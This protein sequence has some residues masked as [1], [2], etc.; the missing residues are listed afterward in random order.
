MKLQSK[1]KIQKVQN[2]NDFVGIKF[3]SNIIEISVPASFREEADK[4]SLKK[5]LLLFLKSIEIAKTINYKDINTK[6]NSGNY[7]PIESYLWIIKDYIE[8]RVIILEKNNTLIKK[9]EKLIGKKH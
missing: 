7:W 6:T 3:D 8:N 4:K 5:D 2:A 1:I 9:M